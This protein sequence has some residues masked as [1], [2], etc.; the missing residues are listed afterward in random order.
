[1]EPVGAW[2]GVGAVLVLVLLDDVVVPVLDVE[3]DEREVDDELDDVVGS[4]S[5]L[6]DRQPANASMTNRKPRVRVRMVFIVD[7]V[8]FKERG[9]VFEVWSHPATYSNSP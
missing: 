1:M 7:L 5:S 3:V 4:G 2:F 6:P 8:L 9:C